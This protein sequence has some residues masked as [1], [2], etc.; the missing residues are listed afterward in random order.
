MLVVLARKLGYS[1][2]RVAQMLNLLKL[3]DEK[4]LEIEWLGDNWDRQVETE[5]QLTSPPIHPLPKLVRVI[6][7]SG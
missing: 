5:R 7:D 4:L 1:R 3:P 2:A 6:Q